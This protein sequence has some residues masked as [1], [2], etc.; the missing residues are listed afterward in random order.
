MTVAIRLGS[1]DPMFVSRSGRVRVMYRRLDSNHREC[2]RG[3]H[4]ASGSR[5]ELSGANSSIDLKLP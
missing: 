4:E 3:A 2:R 1:V 5:R